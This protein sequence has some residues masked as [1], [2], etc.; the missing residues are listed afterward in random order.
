MTFNSERLR[1]IVVCANAKLPLTSKVEWSGWLMVRI[2]NAS[3]AV[4]GRPS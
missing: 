4:S 3:L 1:L 2:R